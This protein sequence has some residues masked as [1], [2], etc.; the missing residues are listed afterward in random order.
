M[1]RERE[2]ADLPI[3]GRVFQRGGSEAVRSRVIDDIY[4]KL[5][6]AQQLQASDRHEE[7]RQERELRLQLTDATQAISALLYVRRSTPGIMDR[8]R[9]SQDAIAIAKDALSAHEVQAVSREHF[10]SIR[11]RAERQ[12]IREDR[13]TTATETETTAAGGSLGGIP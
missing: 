9:L 3:V 12:K 10:R 4:D 8:N 5:Q 11:R 6:A 2:L 7:T 1:E 13:R